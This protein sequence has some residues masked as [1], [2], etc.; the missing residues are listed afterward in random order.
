MRCGLQWVVDKITFPSPPSSYSLTSHPELFFVKSPRSRPGYPGVPCMLYSIPQGAPVLLVHAHSNGCDIGDMRQTLQNISESL[1]VHVMSFEFP[2]YGLH[3]GTASMRTI[4]E[5][6]IAVADFIANDLK[7][8]AAQVVWYGR[9]IGSGPAVRMAHRITKELKE[10]PGGLVVQCGYANFP[11]VA[12]HLFGR[13]AKQLVC[14]LWPN[15]AMMKDLRCPVLLIHGRNDTMIPI[16]QSQKLWEGVKLKELSNFHTCDCGH[17]DFNFRRC[18]LRPIYEFLVKVIASPG[19]PATNFTMDV[20]AASQA[21]VHHIGPLRAKIPVYSFRRPELEEYLQKLLARRQG[22]DVALADGGT[23]EM[24]ENRS[25]PPPAIKANERALILGLGPEE[26]KQ[27]NGLQGTVQA[28]D[29]QADRWWLL[30]DTGES[31][32][33]RSRNLKPSGESVE[34]S[35]QKSIAFALDASKK[36]E[37]KESSRKNSGDV[38]EKRSSVSSNTSTKARKIPATLPPVKAGQ[39]AASKKEKVEQPQIPDFSEMPAEEDIS[40]ALLDPEGMVRTCVARIVAY[41]DRV[42]RQLDRIEGLEN[43]PLEEVVALVEAEFWA[44]DPLLGLWEEVSMDGSRVRFRLGPFSVDN[45]GQRTYD[46]GLATGRT[47]AP[48]GLLRQPLWLFTPS[49]AH[50]RCLAEWS[51]L[52]SARLERNL[53]TAAGTSNS[54]SSCCFNPSFRRSKQKPVKGSG[55]RG[56]GHP[57]PGA[58][59]TSLAAHFVHWVEKK[60]EVTEI[61]RSFVDLHE[62]PES[63]LR[64]A[65]VVTAAGAVSSSASTPLPLAPKE[66][67]SDM[68]PTTPGSGCED[69]LTSREDAASSEHRTGRGLQASAHN[70]CSVEVFSPEHGGQKPFFPCDGAFFSSSSRA[71]LRGVRGCLGSE[72]IQLKAGVWGTNGKRQGTIVDFKCASEMV[73]DALAFDD[74]LESQGLRRQL[75]WTAAGVLLHYERL[76]WGACPDGFVPTGATEEVWSDPLRLDMRRATAAVNRTIKAFLAAE[77][78]E[79]QQQ[80]ILMPGPRV[81]VP[82][83]GGAGMPLGGPPKPADED[84]AKAP[85]MDPQTLTIP[86]V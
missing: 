76:L 77:Q 45:H 48:A 34:A 81:S 60:T 9:S 84:D 61:F 56:A 78:R 30:L 12:G 15:E 22:G 19:F 63:S 26:G 47:A 71:L 67:T 23:A 6:A 54:S 74:H 58:L 80:M 29:E 65:A 5:A 57:S 13:I 50:F 17:N 68:P 1:K 41:L 38:A 69:E 79:R 39:K 70:P 31:V 36:A 43:K 66:L 62:N 3:L 55:R 37:G 40:R 73:A 72:H 52:H 82:R 86:T 35:D 25:D 64:R 32:L 59:A 10:Q 42:Q 33:L 7:V 11:E 49:P 44:S 27:M 53:P 4:D 20:T 75:D 2:G 51:L 14:P 83:L 16:S 28:Y 24:T 46:A 85:A 21:Y 18:T 8:S